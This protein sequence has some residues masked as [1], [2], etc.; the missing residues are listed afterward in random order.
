MEIHQIIFATW[1]T[2]LLL[3]YGFWSIIGFCLIQLRRPWIH[4]SLTVIAKRVNSLS[5]GATE[6]SIK[7]AN[8]RQRLLMRRA[9]F[10]RIVHVHYNVQSLRPPPRSPEN[11]E[12]SLQSVQQ[13]DVGTCQ[14]TA[15]AEVVASNVQVRLCQKPRLLHTVHI[16]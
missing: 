12:S 5:N 2:T 8:K 11:V 3:V 4:N 15:A 7:R 14:L 13:T 9:R 1:L 6:S 10:R 16:E